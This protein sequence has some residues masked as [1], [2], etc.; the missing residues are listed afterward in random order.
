MNSSSYELQWHGPYKWYGDGEN[1]LF[2]RPEIKQPGI[3]L[4]TIPFDEQ[5]LTYCYSEKRIITKE[6]DLRQVAMSVSLLK[7]I[8]ASTKTNFEG[9]EK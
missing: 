3:Y 4:W 6:E 8:I 2:S 7:A 9:G 5:Y 1:V